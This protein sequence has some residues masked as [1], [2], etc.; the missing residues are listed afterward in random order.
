VPI[1]Y[2]PKHIPAQVSKYYKSSAIYRHSSEDEFRRLPHRPAQ[3]HQEIS[4][5][6]NNAE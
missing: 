4:P 6:A 5:G 2:S 1:Q 3:A